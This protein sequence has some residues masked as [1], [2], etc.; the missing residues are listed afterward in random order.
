MPLFVGEITARNETFP[1]VTLFVI[2][3]SILLGFLQ[4]EVS[5]PIFHWIFHSN[6]SAY[7]NIAAKSPILPLY[8][9]EF[10]ARMTYTFI[11]LIV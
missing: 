10:T 6:N 8:V 7:L 3:N 9:G 4:D 1:L 11:G 5:I 2:F